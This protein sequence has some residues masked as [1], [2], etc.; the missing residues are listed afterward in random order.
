MNLSVA[1][2]L[3]STTLL[4]KVFNFNSLHSSAALNKFVQSASDDSSIEKD[5]KSFYLYLFDYAKTHNQK[6][7]EIDVRCNVYHF[8]N[9]DCHRSLGNIIS[10]LCSV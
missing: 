7:M 4:T 6:T 10:S 9:V 8:Y 2:I 5:F 1:L 3:T